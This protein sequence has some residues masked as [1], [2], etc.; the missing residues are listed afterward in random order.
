[1]IFMDFITIFQEIS[2]NVPEI[3][4][5]ELSYFFVPPRAAYL[6]DASKNASLALLEVEISSILDGESFFEQNH[7][8]MRNS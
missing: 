6:S 7:V 5:F 8:I 3:P 1:M 4:N 2:E